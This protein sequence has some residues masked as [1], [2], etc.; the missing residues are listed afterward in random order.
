M[1]KKSMLFFAFVLLLVFAVAIAVGLS[2]SDNG[3]SLIETRS[4]PKIEVKQLDPLHGVVP[5]EIVSANAEFLSPNRVSKIAFNVRNNSE[6]EVRSLCLVYSIIVE[7]DGKET[8]D[9]FYQ[10]IE[11][12]IHPHL[13]A[14][15]S[16]FKPISPGVEQ[17]V[18]DTGGIEYDTDSS[19]AV[20]KVW[21]DYVEFE[22]GEILGKNLKG[23]QLI[24]SIREGAIAYEG[25]LLNHGNV[26]VNSSEFLLEL[27]RNENLPEKLQ[28]GSVQ[29]RSGA[30]A[31][32]NHL[33][34][35][36]KEFGEAG[37]KK[38]AKEHLTS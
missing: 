18:S 32:R 3:V 19:I 30:L 26:K 16:I 5:V 25:W 14:T 33:R 31:Y 12:F 36:Y 7:R 11:T 29:F 38:F 13:R 20:V 35:V 23:Q 8:S 21:I 4:D 10:T 1:L 24:N 27:L 22:D 17:T 37:L 6:R 2:T 34:R 28:V 15:G 9:T